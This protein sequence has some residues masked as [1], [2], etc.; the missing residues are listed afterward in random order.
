MRGFHL[1][2]SVLLCLCLASAAR[3]A[4]VA[5]GSYAGDGTD[6]RPIASV[7]FAPDAVF[8]SDELAGSDNR[9]TVLRTTAM[10]GDLSCEMATSCDVNRIQALRPDGFEIGSDAAVNKVGHTYYYV[11]LKSDDCTPDVA[12]GSYTGDGSDNRTIGTVGFSPSYVL[13]KRGDTGTAAM[14]RFAPEV[15]DASL[16]ITAGGEVTNRIQAFRSAGFEIGSNSAVNAAGDTYYWLAWR[17]GNVATY[18]GN[19]IAGHAV[20]GVGFSPSWVLLHGTGNRQTVHRPASIPAG[21]DE[22]LF[23][24]SLNATSDRIQA[25]T[26]DGFVVGTNDQ[27]NH[28]GVTYFFAALRSG[29]STCP[30]ATST[31]TATGTATRT[32]TATSTASASATGTATSTAT[33]TSTRTPPNTSTATPVDTA[34][35]TATAT[36]VDTATATATGTAT[37]T[38]TPLD[39]ATPTLTNTATATVTPTETPT[40]EDTPTATPTD[41]PTPNDTATPTPLDTATATETATATATQT[42]T[43]S[44]T[45]TPL[46]TATATPVDTATATATATDTPTATATATVTQTPTRTP[47]WTPTQTPTPPLQFIAVYRDGVGGIDGLGGATGVA[48]SPDGARL[49]AAGAVE[50]SIA[51]FNRAAG[52]G[53]LTYVTRFSTGTANFAGDNGV[54]VSPDSVHV[55]VSVLADSRIKVYRS[56]VLGLSFVEDQIDGGA[57]LLNSPLD[58]TVSPDGA[59]VY[60]AAWG[61][62][63]VSIFSR[64]ASTGRLT[65]ASSIGVSYPNRVVISP[66]S[67][68]AYV[69]A[70][71]TNELKV[72]S[73]NTATGALTLLQSLRDGVAGV[74]GLAAAEGLSISGDGLN[75]YATGPDDAAVAVFARNPTTGLLTFVEAKR[76]T[77]VGLAGTAFV[78]VSPDGSR[79]YATARTDDALVVFARDPATGRLIWIQTY[80]DGIGGVDGLDDAHDIALSPD[81]TCL[82][83]AAKADNSVALFRVNP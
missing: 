24:A 63:A 9:E 30:T 13:L 10:A 8:V 6:N 7:G 28:A 14:Q 46:D 56:T 2:L 52:G 59:Y 12:V 78:A 80:R 32:A 58:V 64:N 34:T 26:S 49:Y 5:T 11:A 75:V 68:H 48:V 53:A 39:T 3:A 77:G 81:G 4:L 41:T 50:N 31:T 55:Y 18:G 74:D 40:P 44:G 16:P 62:Q 47:T 20:T 36:P 37:G 1:A 61:D 23:L 73:R 51:V 22:S 27:V 19:G 25:F 45:P 21:V 54:A 38:P 43:P 83:V 71:G 65:F 15:G 33:A 67:A 72:Y 60:A 29:P 66:D 70:E 42:F 17:A 79:V 82:Y 69:T 35:R 76:V 57:I